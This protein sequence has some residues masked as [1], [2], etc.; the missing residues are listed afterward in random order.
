MVWMVV[1]LIMWCGLHFVPGIAPDFRNAVSDRLGNGPY[2]ALFSIAIV[3]SVVLMALGWR[4]ATVTDFHTPPSWGSPV[5][6]AL[7]LL[8]IWLFVLARAT[9][10]IKRFI[11]HPQLAGFA[12]WTIAHLIANG[13]SRSVV[14]F[15]SLGLW[16]LIEIVVIN[17]RD[18]IWA[19]PDP[20]PLMAEVTPAII[21]LVVFA[22]LMFVHPFI[23]GVSP[24]PR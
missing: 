12:T 6:I 13:D 21:A 1:G 8:A 9:S 18:G 10:N 5:A 3:T 19:R 20:A 14:L 22:V 15:G 7:M 4:A 16:A 2:R 11:R 24:I 23:A 17:R